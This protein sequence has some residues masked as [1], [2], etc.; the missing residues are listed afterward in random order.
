MSRCMRVKIQSENLRGLP[1]ST[2]AD[3]HASIQHP[4]F[5]SCTGLLSGSTL[6]Y[7]VGFPSRVLP[8]IKS[9]ILTRILSPPASL[10]LLAQQL[11]LGPSSPLTH[12]DATLTQLLCPCPPDPQPD[13]A[14]PQSAFCLSLPKKFMLLDNVLS[15]ITSSQCL[16]PS[17]QVL[18]RLT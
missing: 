18:P 17:S 8:L 14:N 9:S 5:C 12:I 6:V 10:D 13:P 11:L 4:S 16:P 15:K 3:C 1:C 2:S 7:L